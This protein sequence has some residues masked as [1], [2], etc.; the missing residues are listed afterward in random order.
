MVGSTISQYHILEKLGQGGMGVVYKA[1]DTKLERFVALKF[2]PPHL[3]AS[4]QDKARFAQEAKAAAALNHPNVCSVLDIQEHDGQMFIV[5]E[6][7]DGQT[8]RDRSATL[9]LKQAIDIGIQVADGLA[10][11]HEKGIV[12]RD[13]KPENI[14]IRNDGI[15]QIMDF[16]LAKLRSAGSAINRL[17][18]EGSTVGT[19]G[20]MSPEQVQG[21]D[22]DHRSD[23]FS[24]GVVLYEMFT[25]QLPFKG[26]HET[27]LMY[28][29]VN[30]DAA[31]MSSI[32]PEIDVELD[33]IVLDCLQKEKSERA[34]SAGEVSR[35]LKRVK[36]ES[37][38]QRVSRITAS[39]PALKTQAPTPATT[40]A[41][42]WIARS[43]FFLA[44]IFA[45]AAAFFWFNGRSAGTRIP[46]PPVRAMIDL[47]PDGPFNGA[48][49]SRGLALSHDG[50]MLAYIAKVANG[51]QLY[52]HR[53]DQMTSEPI[54]GTEGAGEPVFS[55]DGQWIAYNSIDLRVSKI[56][57]Q[58][59][60]PQVV[61]NIGGQATRG[62]A[63]T[64]D[65]TLLLGTLNNSIL[66]V[67]ADGGTPQPITVLDTAGG[68]I[69][70][71]Y[72]QMLPNGKAILYVA[73][74]NNITT[75][76][77][78][79]IIAQRLD[80]GER[81]VVIR[82]GTFPKYL[83]T[84]HLAYVR[85][86]QILVA[87]FDQDKLE[88]TGAPVPLETGGWM[89]RGSGGAAMDV[90]GTGTIVF[91]GSASDAMF[92]N[93]SLA[94]MD[95]TGALLPL[96]D[97]LRAYQTAALSPDGQ[98]IAVSINAANNDLWV[99]NIPRGVLTRLTFGGG[100]HDWPRWS[101]DGKYI[102]YAGEKGQSINLFRK[103][104]DG[105]GEEERLTFDP[106]AQL[107]VSTTP[108]GSVLMFLQDGD[109]WQ[110]PLNPS[111]GASAGKPQPFLQS[112]ATEQG[113]QISPDGKWIAYTSNESA[114]REVFV[115]A[116]PKREGK[117]QI[118]TGGASKI[119][120][121]HDG[122]EL[123]YV[124]GKDLMAVTIVPGETFDFSLPR[125]LCEIPAQVILHDVS[126]DGTKFLVV[127]RQDQVTTIQALQVVTGW[128]DLV[129]SKIT[130]TIN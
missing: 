45:L 91:A 87:P 15:A 49:G 64:A 78:A 37:S 113:G 32:K 85:G 68:E 48:T 12:H 13:I 56:S 108:D 121:S 30:V 27:A 43:G 128:F 69:S 51:N 99:Y 20:Y 110:L 41:N 89:N 7:V 104:W 103:P 115:T 119:L 8:L 106:S 26:V 55:P 88:V 54:A 16:G 71:R 124:S 34:Q 84:G 60:A 114:K 80:N 97:T 83:S 74:L 25:G 118:S 3:N 82:G 112:P 122:K 81:K 92:S 33:R 46:D 75:F 24:L 59:G 61:C 35:D 58:G 127:R 100:N 102:F 109:L 1:Q 57:T 17:T 53:M 36:R 130:A 38:R 40:S 23:I 107:P 77:D 5:M 22:A 44:G 79:L 65:N 52:L 14:M 39:R 19:A 6:F 90:S 47:P 63:W 76:D 11:A 111:G 66:R 95:R 94:W 126:L 21:L 72:P 9:S 116:F 29:I 70:H 10:A 129:R 62:I 125:K 101:P 2:L 120:W 86:S 73:K 28:E 123:F 42:P 50:K 96:L 31:P 18:K 4:A 67:S 117:W 105:S 98:K 93:I